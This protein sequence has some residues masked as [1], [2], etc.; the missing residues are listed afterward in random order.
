MP[1]ATFQLGKGLREPNAPFRTCQVFGAELNS[2]STNGWGGI[3]EVTGGGASF[4]LSQISTN[5]EVCVA[6]LGVTNA[7]E[8]DYHIT[9]RWYKIA[10]GELLFT[11]EW[12]WY[13]EEGGWF[14]VYSYIGWVP[15]EINENG[16]YRVMVDV[17]GPWQ[18]SSTLSFSISGIEEEEEEEPEPEPEPEEPTS[19]WQE[20]ILTG[21][22]TVAGLFGNI[23]DR[24]SGWITPFNWLASPFTWIHDRIFSLAVSVGKFFAWVRGVA[25]VIGGLQGWDDIWQLI[26]SNLPWLENIG[27]WFQSWYQHIADVFQDLWRSVTPMIKGWISTAVQSL[28]AIGEAWGNFWDNLWPQLTGWVDELRAGWDHFIKVTL[29]SLPGWGDIGD[30]IDSRIDQLSG[31]WEGWQEIREQVFDFFS[32]PIEYLW[33]RFIDWFLGPEE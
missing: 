28:E 25:D 12:D 17:S 18:K 19:D 16:N 29:P 33:E 26:I 20:A 30:F 3:P 4:D 21:I 23:A 27:E 24:V 14:Y 5:H 15:W 32:N 22:F 7:L 11:W 10:G 2:P 31:F 6:R 8:G 1:S 9:I 13:A